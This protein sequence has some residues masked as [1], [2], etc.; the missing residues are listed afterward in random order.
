MCWC[1]PN[2]RTPCC[3]KP[4]CVP[5]AIVGSLAVDEAKAFREAWDAAMADPRPLVPP[6]NLMGMEV[7]VSIAVPPNT[8]FIKNAAGA[9]IGAIT[10]ISL[11]GTRHE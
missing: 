5:G 9:T 7:K 6:L 1:N 4:G 8:I 10:N 3:G 11:E 2:L